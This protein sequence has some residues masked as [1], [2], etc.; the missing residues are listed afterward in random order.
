MAEGPQRRIAKV[1]RALVN[2]LTMP[3]PLK[4]RFA[5]AS[6]KRQI[7]IFSMTN[8]RHHPRRQFAPGNYR[9]VSVAT[10]S[11]KIA[12]LGGRVARG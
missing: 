2:R 3:C 6:I 5:L 12:R 10:L 9:H 1:D 8:C 7:V 4:C 11:Y